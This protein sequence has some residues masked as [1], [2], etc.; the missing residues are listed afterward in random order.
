MKSRNLTLSTLL[1]LLSMGLSSLVIGEDYQRVAVAYNLDGV[2]FEGTL[3][4]DAERVEEAAKD[5]DL[6]PGLFMVPNWMG[7]GEA[8]NTKAEGIAEDD[9]V[10]FVADVYGV[11]TRPSGREEASA[12]AG[13]LRSGDRQLLRDR[14]AAALQAF[15]GSLGTHNLPVDP[16]EVVA[17]GFCFGGG[18]VLEMARAGANIPGVVSFHGNLDTKQPAEKGT[19]LAK[20]LILHG[21]D[22]P[23]V[24]KE[25]VDAIQEEMRGAGVDWQLMSYGGAV[26]SF[27]N[28][29][30]DS[31]G[32]KYHAVVAN[33]SFEA[34]EDFVEELFG[35][36]E[37]E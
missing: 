34:L 8:A 18:T 23:Y 5:G 22:D 32:S 3:V 30:A 24:S 31:E 21:A 9:Y 11:D 33:R 35:D 19:V 15:Q 29:M 13:K 16:V 27:T 1:S 6:M 26:H 12:A 20:V 10:V 36:Y 28:P 17:I 7:P 14:A 4:Y 2:S 25:S 37:D